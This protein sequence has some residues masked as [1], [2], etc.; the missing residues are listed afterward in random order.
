M[1][2]SVGEF[3]ITFEKTFFFV[4]GVKKR[5]GLFADYQHQL[6]HVFLRKLWLSAKFTAYT[7]ATT[8]Y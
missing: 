6:H 7:A 3:R 8:N 1:L 5:N 2:Y 4:G